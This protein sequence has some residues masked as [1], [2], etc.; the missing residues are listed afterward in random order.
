MVLYG[1]RG[2]SFEYVLLKLVSDKYYIM[3]VRIPG[4]GL[5]W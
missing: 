2:H 1:R 3:M 4:F 5:T